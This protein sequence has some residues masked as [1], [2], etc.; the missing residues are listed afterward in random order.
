MTNESQNDINTIDVVVVRS[1]GRPK[2]LK[3]QKNK[4][5]NLKIPLE[6]L[7]K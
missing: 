3:N 4:M 1:R 7:R 2:N 6:D 5:I